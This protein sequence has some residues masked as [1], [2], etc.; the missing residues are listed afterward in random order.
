MGSKFFMKQSPRHSG[1][2]MTS[3][4]SNFAAFPNQTKGKHMKAPAIFGL[5]VR[6]MGIFFVYQTIHGVI[7]LIDMFNAVFANT[8][9]QQF[10]RGAPGEIFGTTLLHVL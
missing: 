8:F 7:G 3:A 10:S 4:L 6:A 1:L 2:W 5:L 9:N